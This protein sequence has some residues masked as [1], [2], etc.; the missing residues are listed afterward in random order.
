[1]RY[2]TLWLL[3]LV[4]STLHAQ[5]YFPKNDGVKQSFKNYTAIQNA[6]IYISATQKIENATLL[7]KENKIVAVGTT[8]VLPKGSEIIDA[9][10]KHVYPGLILSTS[11]LGLV[12]PVVVLSSLVIALDGL[13]DPLKLR[14]GQ[15]S[16]LV[17]LELVDLDSS[18]HL[19]CLFLN[20]VPGNQLS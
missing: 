17:L 11:Q 13:D 16:V 1:M 20:V 7:I 9:K 19:W 4:S 14:V 8:V 3:L 12:E 18:H 5:D 6:T 2:L 10:G 15:Q